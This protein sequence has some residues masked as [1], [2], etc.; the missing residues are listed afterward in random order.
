M[1]LETF[2]PLVAILIRLNT[3]Y[4]TNSISIHCEVQNLDFHSEKIDPNALD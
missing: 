1:A 4:Y 3:Q 2:W